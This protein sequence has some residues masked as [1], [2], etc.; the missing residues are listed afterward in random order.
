MN[1][2][3]AATRMLQTISTRLISETTRDSLYLQILDAAIT[4]MA[5]DAAS[6][7]E[8]LRAVDGQLTIDT[9]PQR[10]TSIQAR[11]PLPQK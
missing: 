6:M 1:D 11:V 2:I 3:G 4:L 10:G 5:A 8:R 9:K 7:K